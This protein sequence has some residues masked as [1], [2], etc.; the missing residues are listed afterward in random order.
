MNK[1]HQIQ[2]WLI[3][4][5]Q[6]IVNMYYVEGHQK[7]L[8]L[9]SW[10]QQNSVKYGSQRGCPAQGR[11]DG[12]ISPSDVYVYVYIYYIYIYVECVS[13]CVYA[14]LYVRIW[15]RSRNCG[16]LVTW[17]CYQLIAIPGNKTATVSWPDPYTRVWIYVIRS[18]SLNHAFAR[19]IY[20]IGY[21]ILEYLQCHILS[22][23]FS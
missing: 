12:T 5:T 7:S 3:N 10:R 9:S 2:T 15:V 23:Y 13:L 16:C 19:C 18:F 8:S 17:F 4:H 22:I 14:F 1:I 20:R 11:T 21:I 6:D